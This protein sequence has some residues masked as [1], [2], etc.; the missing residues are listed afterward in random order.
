MKYSLRPSLIALSTMTLGVTG[1]SSLMLNNSFSEVDDIQVLEPSGSIDQRSIWI[2][3]GIKQQK[4]TSGLPAK[5]LKL[6]PT[7]GSLG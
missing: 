4:K 7:A 5:D 1:C 3:L 2:K 6:S